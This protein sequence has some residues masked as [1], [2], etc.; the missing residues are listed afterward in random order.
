MSVPKRLGALVGLTGYNY[1]LL[2]MQKRPEWI[3]R[4][5]ARIPFRQLTFSPPCENTPSDLVLCERLV[6]A[7]RKALRDTSE[8]QDLSAIWSENTRH[9]NTKLV[10]ALK[11]GDPAPLA[12]LLSA[13]FRQS[14][15]YGIAT[16]NLYVDGRTRIGSR[17]WSLK[18]LDDLVSLAESLGVVRTE[19]PE[20][21]VLGYAFCDGLEA[22]V[23]K[24]E[25][26]LGMRIGF[27]DVGAPYGIKIADTLITVESSEHIYAAVRINQAIRCQLKPER[28]ATPNIVEIGGGFGGTGY[29]LMTLRK[30]AGGSYTM[31]DLP[32]ANV[33]QGYFLSKVLGESQVSLYGESKTGDAV[34]TT[35]RVLPTTA[36]HSLTDW[37]ADVLINQNS[38]PEMPEQAVADYLCWARD[39]LQGFFYSY[40]QE[41]YSPVNGIPQVL[42]PAII[43]RVGG[44][45]LLSRNCSWLRRGYVEEVY[46]REEGLTNRT[47]Q[48]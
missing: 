35:V 36:I 44:F 17:V 41:A 39:N 33:L 24:I 25:A 23:A 7:Y 48:G 14:F 34:Q 4:G 16:G 6:T 43:A 8:S 32:L 19:C 22:L 21:G 12:G 46:A 10:S 31:I 11:Q 38:M 42:V 3:Y 2:R 29:W 27:P 40:N 20:Q 15:L 28:A 13:M 45:R 18:C 1:Y 30:M 47:G 37:C 9:H 26:A 5:Y